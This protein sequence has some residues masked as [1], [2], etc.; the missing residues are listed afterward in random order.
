MVILI[1]HE[2]GILPWSTNSWTY[3]EFHVFCFLYFSHAQSYLGKWSIRDYVSTSCQPPPLFSIN[4]ITVDLDYYNYFGSV[5]PVIYIYTF[6]KTFQWPTSSKV[7]VMVQ[8]INAIQWLQ[9]RIT[10]NYMN[11]SSGQSLCVAPP[12]TNMEPKN[13]VFS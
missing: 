10:E 9:D 3:I 7:I 13:D 8:N 4:Q 6:D 11:Y 12:P 1:I 2:M 5:W